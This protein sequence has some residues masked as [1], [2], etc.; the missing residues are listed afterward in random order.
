[1]ARLNP[2]LITHI[3][4]N[5]A[6]SYERSGDVGKAQPL[7]LPL[8]VLHDAQLP[9]L[10]VAA[11]WFDMPVILDPIGASRNTNGLAD[12]DVI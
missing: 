11:L 4:L 8:C 9:L 1:M 12:R 2:W 10:K 3:P 7:L 6:G 5:E